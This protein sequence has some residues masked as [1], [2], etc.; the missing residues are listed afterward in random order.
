[1]SIG[2]GSILLMSTGVVSIGVMSLLEAGLGTKPVDV[3]AEGPALPAEVTGR[4]GNQGVL[5]E[6]TGAISATGCGEDRTGS[7]APR[8]ELASV[9]LDRALLMRSQSAL[10]SASM[11]SGVALSPS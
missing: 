4:L 8:P 6:Q 11:S 9:S 5:G 1:M 10:F 2:V 7:G 3:Q